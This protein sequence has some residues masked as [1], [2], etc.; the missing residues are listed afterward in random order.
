MI[1]SNW[2]KKNVF[3]MFYKQQQYLSLNHTMNIKR[4]AIMCEM[5]K[6]KKRT[7]K[8]KLK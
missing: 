6:K 4:E 3:L 8:N 7:V 5:G 1:V 2:F